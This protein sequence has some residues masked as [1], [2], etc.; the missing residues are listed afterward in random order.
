MIGFV[1]SMMTLGNTLKHSLGR[2]QIYKFITDFLAQTINPEAALL[3]YKKKYALLNQ[4]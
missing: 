2:Y 4:Q 1:F 3:H